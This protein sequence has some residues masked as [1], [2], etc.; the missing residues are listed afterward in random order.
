MKTINNFDGLFRLVSIVPRRP[1]FKSPAEQA[2]FL[3]KEY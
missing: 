2:I 3:S 1:V